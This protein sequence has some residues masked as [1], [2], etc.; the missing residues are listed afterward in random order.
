MDFESY[1]SYHQAEIIHIL[2]ILEDLIKNDFEG[3]YLNLQLNNYLIVQIHYC[4]CFIEKASFDWV[5]ND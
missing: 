5:K 4:L 3:C 2:E 1:H